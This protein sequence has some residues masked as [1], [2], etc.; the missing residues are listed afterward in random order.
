MANLVPANL[1][2][3]P[4]DIPQSPHLV[5]RAPLFRAPAIF[6]DQPINRLHREVF[7][8]VRELETRQAAWRSFGDT[9]VTRWDIYLSQQRLLVV[10]MVVYQSEYGFGNAGLPQQLS[11]NMNNRFTN[12]E[13]RLTNMNNQFNNRFTNTEQRLTNME[14]QLTNMEQRLTNMNDQFQA[15]PQRIVVCLSNAR[16]VRAPQEYEYIA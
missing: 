11:T 6:A 14:Q 15:L 1:L 12:M 7:E 5:S 16:V 4:I 3:F 13:Q 9:V 8:A 2:L 10:K